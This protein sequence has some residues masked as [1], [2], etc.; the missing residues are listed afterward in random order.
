MLLFVT[1]KCLLIVT[2]FNGK[3]EYSHVPEDSSLHLTYRSNK[4]RVLK[5]V[6]MVHSFILMSL[7]FCISSY[8]YKK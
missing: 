4:Y 3:P 5:S 1:L 6:M 7:L 8:E 2:I